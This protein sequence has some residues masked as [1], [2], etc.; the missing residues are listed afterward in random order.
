[1]NDYFSFVTESINKVLTQQANF[2]ESEGLAM[3]K[4]IT[5]ILFVW[6]GIQSALASAEG[7]GGFRWGRF[8]TL[9]W[10]I[11][12]VYT[13]LAFYTVPIPG[14]GI[15]FT[16][17][18]LDQVTYLV[19]RLN[20]AK[21]QEIIETLNV[22]ESSLPYPSS[23][24]LIA[25]F[26]FF[27]VFLAV[28]AAQAVTLAVIIFGYV[29]TAVLILI[30]PV[31]IPFKLVPQMDWLFWGWFRAFI[32]YAFYQVVASLYVFVF[33]DFLLQLLGG[34]NTPLS[35]GD[36]AANFVPMLLVLGVFILGTIK[37][38]SLVF[39]LFSGRSGDYVTLRW[40]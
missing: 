29:A 3:F 13:M 1:M 37:I 5:L 33:G 19:E 34:K 25:I 18:I 4:S 22:V 26:R 8:T 32:Q 38:P 9:L 27:I 28:L 21:M 24:E 20:Q 6:F 35:S 12:L 36:F 2:F 15:S 30:G 40:R 31:F 14:L 39:S 17:L 10:E 23:Y 16:H 11:L 7:A